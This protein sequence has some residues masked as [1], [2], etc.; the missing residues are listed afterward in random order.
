MREA[1]AES[2]RDVE[3][4]YGERE[5]ER[6]REAAP[7]GTSCRGAGLCAKGGEIAELGRE[8]R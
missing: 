6:G 1:M 4:V 2:K 7:D 3:M 8:E 5:R